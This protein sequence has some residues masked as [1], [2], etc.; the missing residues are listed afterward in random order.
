MYWQLGDIIFDKL[1]GFSAF[2]VKTENE[3]AQHS[4]I[5]GKPRLQSTGQKA[6]VINI[7]IH[8]NSAFA[9]PEV[10]YQKLEGYRSGLNVLTLIGGDGQL[11]GDFVI[12]SIDAHVNQTDPSG[13]WVDIDCDLELLENYWSD[14]QKKASQDASDNAFATVDKLPVTAPTLIPVQ[15]QN[16]Q[17]MG[18]LQD[19][20]NKANQTGSLITKA[21]QYGSQ[22]NGWM[23]K[24]SATLNG[25]QTSMNSL[26]S[27]LSNAIGLGSSAT[28]LLSQISGLMSASTNLQN[29]LNNHDL[30]NSTQLFQQFAQL[31]NIFMSTGAP[32][33]GMVTLRQ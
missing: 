20:N 10:Q 9:A 33:A 22:A 21:Q 15:G 12:Q 27:K 2:E 18:N 13:K 7:S 26:Q 14:N 1:N 8:I 6:N 4:L 24:A 17:I 19:V 11:Y 29:T 16:Q 28:N 25:Y 23:D 31:Q 30:L 5:E 32:I 3:I